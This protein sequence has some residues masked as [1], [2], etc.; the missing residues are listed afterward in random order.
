ME[1]CI[2]CKIISGELGSAKIY[3]NDE[4]KVMLDRFP[5]N[6][7]HVL[8][9]TKKHVPNIFELDPETGGRLFKLAVQ[10]SNVMKKALGI[11]NMNILQ[12]NGT[13]AGQTVEHFHLHLIPRYDN[14][15]I[16]ISWEP[17]SPTDEEIDEIRKQ[18]AQK[19]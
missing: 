17:K 10:I 19:L 16:H 6:P 1:N 9:L 11:S 5:S 15:G 2:F 12:N 14:D 8:I 4:F 3:E 7:G 18:I 13:F